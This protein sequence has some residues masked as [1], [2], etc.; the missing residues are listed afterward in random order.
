MI[1]TELAP[2]LWRWTAPHP[3]WRQA[4]KRDSPSDWPR[5]VGCVVAHAGDE[6]AVVID[7]LVDDDDGWTWL[8]ARADGRATHVLTTISFHRRSRDEALERLAADREVPPGVEPFRLKGA[9]ETVFWLPGH[10]ALVPGDRLIGTGTGTGTGG[11][12]RMCPESWLDG[13]GHAELRVLLAPLLELPV[14]R[15]VLSHGAP[16]LTGAREQ[17]AAAIRG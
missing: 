17:L 15:I 11:G 5:D 8:A 1:A 7:P 14:E 16:V 6:H 12:V 10:A 9:R 2:G 4:R 13:I 3:D